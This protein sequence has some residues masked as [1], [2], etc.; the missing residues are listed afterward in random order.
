MQGGKRLVTGIA[1]GPC[2]ICALGKLLLVVL[3]L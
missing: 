3:Y 2:M 1:G